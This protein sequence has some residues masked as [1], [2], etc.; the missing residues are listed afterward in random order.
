M[1]KLDLTKKYRTYYHAKT[2]PELVNIEPARFISIRGKGDP[3]AASFADKIET[4]Y[5]TAYAI[6]FM[7]KEKGL[8]FV[9]PKLEGQWWFDTN[10]FQGKTITTSTEVPREEWEYRLLIR[11]P[12]YVSKQDVEEAKQSVIEKKKTALA[13]E[14]EFFELHEGTSVQMLHVGPFSTEHASLVKIEA[15]TSEKNL[16]QAGL[17]HEIYLSDFRK[18]RPEKLKTIL[19]EPV[20]AK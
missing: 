10:R 5:P 13:D 2:T 8:D 17:H 14:I 7:F 15:F 6:K 19:R 18:T 20:K 11:M 4:L 3:S 16:G 12:D 9:V 1:E